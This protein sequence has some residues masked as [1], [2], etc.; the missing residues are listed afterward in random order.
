MAAFDDLFGNLFDLNGDGE[1]NFTEEFIN[2]SILHEDC[3]EEDGTYDE[4][5]DW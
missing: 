5:E 1:T 4:N 2:F 3:D